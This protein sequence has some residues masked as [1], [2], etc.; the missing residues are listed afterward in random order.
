MSDVYIILKHIFK[1]SN[2]NCIMNVHNICDF[3]EKNFK[4][5]TWDHFKYQTVSKY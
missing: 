5:V 2:E 1:F 4:N 3:L